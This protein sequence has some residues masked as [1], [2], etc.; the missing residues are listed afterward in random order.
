MIKC[1]IIDDEIPALR[2]LQ[3]LCEQFDD[4]EIVRSFNRPTKFIAE[5]AQLDFNTCI[6]DIHMPGIDGLRLAKM[7]QGTAVIFSTAHKEFAAEAF[8]LDAVDYMRKPYQLERLETALDKARHWLGRQQ[9]DRDSTVEL[10]MALGK[11]VIVVQDIVYVQV[12]N[13]D[14]RDKNIFLKT[15]INLLAKNITLDELLDALPNS[16]FCRIN[17]KTVVGLHHI[18]AY[19]SPNR[20]LQRSG[21]RNAGITTFLVLQT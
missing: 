3:A 20:Q 19:Y 7:L 15:G 21:A 10:T 17:R 6:L 4:V 2:Y 5:R 12:G 1:V 18:E 11:T 14:R 13:Q 9:S 16:Q 8:D